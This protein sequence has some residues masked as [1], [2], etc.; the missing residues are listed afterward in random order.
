M[1]PFI[2]L[3]A[4]IGGFFY[5][6]SITRFAHQSECCNFNKWKQITWSIAYCGL[7]LNLTDNNHLGFIIIFDIVLFL[8][9][10]ILKNF[11][12]WRKDLHSARWSKPC[13]RIQNF[14]SG[15]RFSEESI[16]SG[17]EPTLFNLWR[18]W[19]CFQNR[20]KVRIEAKWVLHH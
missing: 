17:R 9:I 10:K 19:P 4:L 20:W 15:L 13:T 8:L 14:S 5:F 3:S 12:Y 1:W 6:K 11:R 18:K 7:Y 2:D 16:P